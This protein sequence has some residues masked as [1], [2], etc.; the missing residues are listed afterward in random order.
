MATRKPNRTEPKGKQGI[1]RVDPCGPRKRRPASS[2]SKRAVD[3]PL[4]G[5]LDSSPRS[6]AICPR[7][8]DPEE[9]S[10]KI[11]AFEA[12]ECINGLWFHL[13]QGQ[14]RASTR[15]LDEAS[16]ILQRL[17]ATLRGL[18]PVSEYTSLRRKVV[19]P[20]QRLID[21]IGS[22]QHWANLCGVCDELEQYPE[23]IDLG[24]LRREWAEPVR[25]TLDAVREALL[26]RIGGAES[27][28][29][30]LGE[31]VDQGLRP[32][33][34]DPL[35][36]PPAAV[37]APGEVGRHR[38]AGEP[39]RPGADVRDDA[40]YA[41]LSNVSRWPGELPAEPGW[42]DD[43]S[44]LMGS[45]P[46]LNGLA[47]GLLKGCVGESLGSGAV[48][49]RLKAG[50]RERLVDSQALSHVADPEGR[51]RVASN[52]RGRN[53]ERDRWLYE[54]MKNENRMLRHILDELS[55]HGEWAVLGSVQSLRAAVI[56]YCKQNKLPIPPPRK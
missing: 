27:L 26:G 41:S 42:R 24:R 36:E 9:A 10:K 52:R 48:A 32:P 45:L 33:G 6:D 5:P 44:R 35:Y 21:R 3:G 39:P 31:V 23:D 29:L 16:R 30:Q 54:Q 47:D 56:R 34:L 1:H 53:G 15:H 17:E 50:I 51:Q 38:T 4:E 25:E 12:G 14:L 11:A 22:P 8:G 55:T 20:I 49:E 28:L 7:P 40:K 13:V 19:P 2:P 46:E 43:V 37:S 18:V